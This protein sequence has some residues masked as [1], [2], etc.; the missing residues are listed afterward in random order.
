VKKHI[1]LE[2]IASAAGVSRATVSYV[3]NGKR[4]VSKETADKIR[5]IAADLG[6]L[7]NRSS[8]SEKDRAKNSF[9]GFLVLPNRVQ[10][11]E[12]TFVISIQEGIHYSL[13]ASGQFLVYHRLDEFGDAQDPALLKF[14]ESVRGLIIL[15]P[16]D[17]EVY[18]N[19]M[20][21]LG[22]RGIPHVLIGS[23]N[24]EDTT[25]YV[26]MDVVSAAYQSS[27][28]LLAKECKR[29]VYID[30]HKGMKQSSQI[31]K[32]FHL[33]H[34]ERDLPWLE[35]NLIHA[36]ETSIEEGVRIA[37]SIL[38]SGTKVDGFIT[39]NDV[40]ARGV[41]I[42]LQQLQVRVPEDCKVVSLG[43]GVI[44]RQIS[45]PR[46]SAV[47]YNPFQMGSEAAGML[48]EII[49]KKRMRPTHSVFPAILIERETS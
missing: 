45:Y 34:E 27:S 41:I 44:S 2:D 40:L 21:M 3:L 38:A 1:T 30:S 28:L 19:F 5:S 7:D 17:D 25:Y 8:K 6:Y 10:P 48:Q 18:E 36:E 35:E 11:D 49:S 12:D 31:L 20:E 4:K 26:D 47:D 15:N 33:A 32:G 22:V 43:G 46:I 16:G 39:P 29:I 37:R 23:P 13:K 24:S 9:I 14:I 42:A